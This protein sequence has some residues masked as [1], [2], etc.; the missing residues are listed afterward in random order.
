MMTSNVF[1]YFF[2]VNALPIINLS[3]NC[4]SFINFRIYRLNFIKENEKNILNQ[5]VYTFEGGEG[6]KLYHGMTIIIVDHKI[7]YEPEWVLRKN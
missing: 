1:F 6:L 7:E 2:N 4:L 3:Y 5:W